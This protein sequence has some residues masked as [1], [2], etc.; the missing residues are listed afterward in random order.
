MFIKCAFP[1]CNKSKQ[2]TPNK[3]KSPMSGKP[4]RAERKYCK[5]HWSV[6]KKEP[7]P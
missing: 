3:N 2:D 1:G 7:K 4:K 6:Q 5:E